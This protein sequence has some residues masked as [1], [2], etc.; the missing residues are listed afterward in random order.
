[1]F[2]CVCA[3]VSGHVHPCAAY[4]VRGGI[5]G[6]KSEG[7]RPEGKSFPWER[8]TGDATG[9]SE[10]QRE[11]MVQVVPQQLQ[12]SAEGLALSFLSSF[13]GSGNSLYNSTSV[14]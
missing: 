5:D 14:S 11:K 13:M 12:L 1:M 7:G 3:C 8:G 2:K 9:V 10:S 4:C 6:M